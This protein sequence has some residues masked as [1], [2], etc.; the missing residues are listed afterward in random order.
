M[1][2]RWCQAGL[3]VGS[4]LLVAGC[5]DAPAAPEP[6]AV[7][8]SNAPS[9][10][11]EVGDRT[12]LTAIVSGGASTVT[13][14]V[15]WSSS[16]AAVAAVSGIG[17]VTAVGPGDATITA[18]AEADRSRSAAVPITVNAPRITGI[19]LSMPQRSLMAGD[20]ASVTAVV[21]AT[22]MGTNRRVRFS[23]TAPQIATVTSTDGIT[24][25]VTA[26]SPGDVQIVAVAELSEFWTASVVVS[27]IGTRAV[28]LTITPPSGSV[29]LGGTTA[30]VA[31][32][33]D[34]AGAPLTAREVR[35]SSSSPRVASVS[36]DGVVTGVALGEATITA[37]MPEVP[38][39]PTLLRAEAA[40]R[41][42]SGLQLLVTPREVTQLLTD[43]VTLGVSVLGDAPGVDRTVDFVSRSPA[44]ASV[45]ASGVVSM[46]ATGTAVVV[47][48]LR[49]DT[50]V[51]D[52]SMITVLDPCGFYVTHE[53]GTVLRGAFT[54]RSCRT[55]VGGT[56]AYNQTIGFTVGQAG[57]IAYRY[58]GFV[59]FSD[60]TL[61]FPDGGVGV[62]G[63][64][65]LG[66]RAAQRGVA[67]VTAGLYFVDAFA[68]DLTTGQFEF[69]TVA[70]ADAMALCGVDKLAVPGAVFP[71]VLGGGCVTEIVSGMT[72]VAGGRRVQ[73]R[74]TSPAF[75][76]RLELC[77]PSRSCDTQPLAAATSAGPGAPAAVS[78]FNP[79][80]GARR[81]YL[82]LSSATAGATTGAI[83]VAIE[84]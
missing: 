70:G 60:F 7:A 26:V 46:V 36:E 79:G 68:R 77:D 75:A 81:W 44:V 59:P 9:V 71:V 22:G 32:P 84:P 48:Q 1:A 61:P 40:V 14:T 23:S 74:A 37:T 8:I 63:Y 47:A 64:T 49:A 69:E 76:V 34:V 16:N 27:V 15:T 12:A 25:T 24:A 55:D 30:L 18:T 72:L 29:T 19:T 78:Y 65:R 20:R 53:V 31:T 83:Q 42:R 57:P 80:V 67:Y 33:R 5:G 11:L 35:W 56:P 50:L 62:W 4:L 82:R 6:V 66:A 38:G 52:S 43:Q 45:N 2:M 17:E 41:V 39:S 54:P 3:L 51:R 28:S 58:Q 73:V 13:R 10:G 21:S